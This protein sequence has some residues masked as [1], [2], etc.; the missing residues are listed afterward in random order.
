MSVLGGAVIAGMASAMPQLGMQHMPPRP[1]KIL[2]PAKDSNHTP[3][4]FGDALGK[5][6]SA[7][8]V[9]GCEMGRTR[10]AIMESGCSSDTHPLEIAQ[11]CFPEKIQKLLRS[12]TFETANQPHIHWPA[13]HGGW[14]VL[15][16]D[17]WMQT[18]PNF[19]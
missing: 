14:Y 15:F 10:I 3:T 4:L 5:W 18:L 7:L 19:T 1:K 16:L 12:I 13:R 11:N 9:S 2:H 17:V 8:I 6:K